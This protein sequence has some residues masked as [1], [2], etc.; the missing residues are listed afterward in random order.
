MS[1]WT[2]Q[3]TPPHDWFLCLDVEQY[4]D[5]E[6]DPEKVFEEG[7]R[8]PIPV[9]DRDVM[10]TTFFNG[11][12]DHPEFHF[13]SEEALDKD[14]I[15]EANKSLSRIFGTDLDLRPLY[16]QAANDPVLETKL[17]D[18]YGLKRMARANLFEDTINR[19]IQMRLSHKPTAKKMV[20]K[21]RKNY[22]SLVTAKGDN[23]PAWPRP[24]QLV[25]ADPMSIRK[26]GPTKRKGEFIIG[27]AEDL[28]SGEQDLEHLE[29]CDPQTFYKT[30]KEVRG[31]GPTSAQQLM[32]FRNRTDACFPSNKTSGKEKGLRKWIVLNY[33]EDPDT[34]AEKDFK[35]LITNWK[36]YEASALE[37][38]FVSWILNEKEK[39]QK[40]GD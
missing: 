30:I 36:G 31:V 40:S 28:L 13:E 34:I 38:L 22:G 4:F 10:V 1:N 8:R 25:K 20:Y 32:L 24:H 9:G 26:L 18:L 23:I 39:K 16:D 21:V 27:F 17:T 5:H 37:F 19:I 3:S 35:Q 33:G 12:P 2:L 7:F 11:D 6:H 29:S 14:E 15:S